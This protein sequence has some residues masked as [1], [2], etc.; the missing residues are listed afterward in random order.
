MADNRRTHRYIRDSRRDVTRP[1]TTSVHYK[2]RS[3]SRTCKVRSCRAWR[4]LDTLGFCKEEEEEEEKCFSFSIL[5]YQCDTCTTHR[6][7]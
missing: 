4:E 1:N 5:Q 7:S 3:T 6:H 2:S